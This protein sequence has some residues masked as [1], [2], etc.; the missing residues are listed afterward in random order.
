MK[1]VAVVGGGIFGATA[2]IHAARSGHEVHLFEKQNNLL[3]AASRINQYRLHRGYHYPRSL[4][5][6]T[7]CRDAE[8]SFREEYGDAMISDSRHLY[9]I[10]R[11]GSRVSFEVFLAFC[12]GNM[13]KYR[14]VRV[15]HLINADLADVVEVD[16]ASFDFDILLSLVKRKLAETGV[17]VNLAARVTG[18]IVDQ[19]DKIVLAAYACANTLLTEMGAAASKYQY[20]VCEKPVVHLP[21]SFGRTDIVIMDGPFM[22]I[23]PLGRTDAYVLGH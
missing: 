10:A 23:G 8:C 13:L 15:P 14:L 1:R 3:Q 20:E 19:F 11:E 16:E 18:S 6:A 2:A 17:K 22:N 12:E 9:G 5:T 7:S 4:D 21:A